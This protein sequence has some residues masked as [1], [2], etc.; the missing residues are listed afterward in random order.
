MQLF[1]FVLSTASLQLEPDGHFHRKIA[2]SPVF[3]ASL[4][5]LRSFKYGCPTIH[6]VQ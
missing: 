2:V 6:I 3:L 4:Y 5:A 1:G